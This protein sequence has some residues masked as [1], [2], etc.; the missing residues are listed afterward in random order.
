MANLI[1]G[2]TT[3]IGTTGY[4]KRGM[5]A[6]QEWLADGNVGSRHDFLESLKAV[7]PVFSEPVEADGIITFTMTDENG[8]HEVR[9]HSAPTIVGS[10]AY[11]DRTD[12]EFSDGTIVSLYG[13]SGAPGPK[14]DSGR[15]VEFRTMQDGIVYWKYTEDDSNWKELI[16]IADI[17]E[18]EVKDQ[19]DAYPSYMYVYELPNIEDAIPGVEYRLIRQ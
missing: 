9:L 15:D 17:A 11:E 18:Q 1:D 3:Y 8:T 7:S 10:T 14:G 19:L 2:N 13:V 4:W 6:Y 16:N 5:S 12:V